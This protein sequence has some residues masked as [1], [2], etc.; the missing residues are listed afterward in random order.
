VLSRLP[1]SPL[2]SSSTLVNSCELLIS[3]V[4][5]NDYKEAVLPQPDTPLPPGEFDF[6]DEEDK[7][8]LLS[9]AAVQFTEH[10]N[11]EIRANQ[12]LYHLLE[13]YFSTGFIGTSLFRLCNFY[14]M[15]FLEHK[16]TVKQTSPSDL[17]FIQKEIYSVLTKLEST[18]S[19]P[20]H[21]PHHH[22]PS[23]VQTTPT[24]MTPLPTLLILLQL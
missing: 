12:F 20:L 23:Q 9:P 1:I 17:L 19:S 8:E 21:T 22:H 2:S 18:N 16:W 3:T 10:I 14:L 24:F 13:R 11:S 5:G 6:K 15:H 4:G 7:E